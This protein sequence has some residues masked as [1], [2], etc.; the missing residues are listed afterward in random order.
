[1]EFTLIPRR[2][3]AHKARSQVADYA[4]RPPTCDRKDTYARYHSI[5]SSS[6]ESCR[7]SS[8]RKVCQLRMRLSSNSLIQFSRS[9]KSRMGRQAES[10]TY[11]ECWL[12][13]LKTLVIRRLQQFGQSTQSGSK[14]KPLVGLTSPALP[15]SC[16]SAMT[17]SWESRLVEW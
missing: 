6:Q 13:I 17:T 12:G 3:T 2:W 5:S 10:L 7:C 8:S 11:F 9:A 16:N 1:M 4:W 15:T 14:A